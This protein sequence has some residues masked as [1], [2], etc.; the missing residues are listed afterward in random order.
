MSPAPYC[1]PCN[2]HHV[3]GSTSRCGAERLGALL[4]WVLLT[5]A[6]VIVGLAL[7]ALSVGAW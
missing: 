5:L 2:A 7:G 1:L 4:G 6:M 3:P